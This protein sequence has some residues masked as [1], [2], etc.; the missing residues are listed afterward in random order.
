[1][2]CAFRIQELHEMDDAERAA[3][4]F[5][6]RMGIMRKQHRFRR[7]AGPIITPMSRKAICGRLL[8]DGRCAHLHRRQ[9]PVT[10]C[11][12]G[13]PGPFCSQSFCGAEPESPQRTTGAWSPMLTVKAAQKAQNKSQRARRR[14]KHEVA[15]RNASAEE[16]RRH[17][18]LE[19]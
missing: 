7:R 16:G 19:A 8:H 12:F 1:M 3:E 15:A 13:K 2:T 6:K 11:R 9:E 17:S 18:A 14:V 4:A 5:E 10:F